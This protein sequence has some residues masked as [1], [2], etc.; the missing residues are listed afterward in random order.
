MSW[1]VSATLLLIAWG[2]LAFGS[3]YP[4]GFLPLFGGCALVGAA[5]VMSRPCAGR[6]EMLLAVS[7]VAVVGAIG[8][9]IIPV[10]A[11]T[12]RWLSPETDVVL[13]RYAIG[14]SVFSERH[15]LSIEPAATMLAL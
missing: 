2:A 5:A 9:Q 10:Q 14:Y 8:A 12:I 11:T 1:R 13:R 7:L 6:V 4:W 3:V 15:A